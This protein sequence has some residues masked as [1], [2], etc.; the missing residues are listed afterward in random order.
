MA[1]HD[2]RE[3][4]AQRLR[5]VHGH[6]AAAAQAADPDHQGGFGPAYFRERTDA[7]FTTDQVDECYEF[8]AACVHPHPSHL[9]AA[10]TADGFSA[11]PADGFSAARQARL[12]VHA[13]RVQP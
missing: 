12:R 5:G 1:S 4:A 6:L 3:R 11:A 8:F 7:F 13:G 9:P 2:P 10:C